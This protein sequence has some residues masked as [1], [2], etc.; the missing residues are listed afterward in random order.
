MFWTTGGYFTSSVKVKQLLEEYG[1]ESFKAEVRKIFKLPQ[2]A[3]NYEYRFLDRVNALNKD[4]WLNKNLGGSKF[5]NVGPMSEKAK[6]ARKNIKMTPE[7]NKKR[8]DAMK[9]IPKSEKTKRLMS[10]V[11]KNRPRD[12]EDARRDKIR[13]AATGR[14][15]NDDTKT[16]LSSIVSKTRWIKKIL[17][18]RK[19]PSMNYLHTLN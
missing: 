4:D 14:G 12:Q 15:H 18:N 5:R 1:T 6:S 8:S 7:S 13:V 3:L 2:Q 17:N 19:Y 16:K 9:G 10:E 11:Q